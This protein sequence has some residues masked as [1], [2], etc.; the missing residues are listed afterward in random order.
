MR[1]IWDSI[2]NNL[3]LGTYDSLLGLKR[4]L[5][6]PKLYREWEWVGSPVTVIENQE[7]AWKYC[8]IYGKQ[9]QV[10]KTREITINS[11]TIHQY[12]SNVPP[13]EVF[14]NNTNVTFMTFLYKINIEVFLKNK[15]A[16]SGNWTHNW[17]S[18]V[19]WLSNKSD[20]F[21]FW[22]WIIS[23]FNRTWLYKDLKV[24]Y[25]QGMSAK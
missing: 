20:T 3:E 22:T 14:V 18:L 16:S 17:P 7:L 21:N 23:S 5:Q 12:A 15:V 19:W 9:C 6:N 2:W 25:C 1:N 10:K 4:G 11:I 24:W 8:E 13:V